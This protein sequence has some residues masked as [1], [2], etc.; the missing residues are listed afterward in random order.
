MFRTPGDMHEN[1]KIADPILGSVSSG[2]AV[3]LGNL[4]VR[5]TLH[6]RQSSCVADYEVRRNARQ[7]SLT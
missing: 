7:V 1:V 6:S 2:G 3:A 4:A 5:E